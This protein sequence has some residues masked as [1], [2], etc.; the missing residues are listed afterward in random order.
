MNDLDF[1]DYLQASRHVL[2]TIAH[3]RL[4]SRLNAQ[5]SD[6]ELQMQRLKNSGNAQDKINKS[7]LTSLVTTA[8]EENRQLLDRDLGPQINTKIRTRKTEKT[9]LATDR[10]TIK[11]DFVLPPEISQLEV[12]AR[13]HVSQLK[14]KLF[15]NQMYSA[16]DN[17]DQSSISTLGL[18]Q[19]DFSDSNLEDVTIIWPDSIST[20]RVTQSMPRTVVSTTGPTH[21]SVD[22]SVDTNE[23]SRIHY[24]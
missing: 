8:T 1:I 18:D 23:P 15:H 16:T 20:S 19:L 11:T 4:E 6:F 5:L 3:Q 7:I 14:A 10:S 21:A 22:M 12:R 17:C 2:L 9:T 13:S 24:K